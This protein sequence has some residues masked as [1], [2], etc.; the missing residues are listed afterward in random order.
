[1]IGKYGD[2]KIVRHVIQGIMDNRVPLL[3]SNGEGLKFKL[4]CPRTWDM[5]IDAYLQGQ[6]SSIIEGL[7]TPNCATFLLSF[8]QVDVSQEVARSIGGR[9]IQEVLRLK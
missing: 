7:L 4:S 5:A 9:A 3:E 2:N 1:M 8:G 6:D